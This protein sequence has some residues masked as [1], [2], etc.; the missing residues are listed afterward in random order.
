[1]VGVGAQQP[2]CLGIVVN[3][4]KSGSNYLLSKVRS[5]PFRCKGVGKATGQRSKVLQSIAAQL[6]G[7]NCG[8]SGDTRT[9]NFFLCPVLSSST[10]PIIYSAEKQLSYWRG[11]TYC[12]RH[13]V[14]CKRPLPLAVRAILV[15]I[16]PWECS[17]DKWEGPQTPCFAAATPMHFCIGWQNY[18]SRKPFLQQCI[19]DSLKL[20]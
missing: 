10:L 18:S 8:G 3:S 2:N 5:A 12:R 1:M 11:R 4:H 14:L 17:S 15:A 13:N 9:E 7:S 6:A 19:L 16:N 20:A